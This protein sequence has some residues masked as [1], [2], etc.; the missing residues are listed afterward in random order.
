MEHAANRTTEK[1]DQGEP[2]DTN[3]AILKFERNA[4]RITFREAN[5]RK[6]YMDMRRWELHLRH[7]RQKLP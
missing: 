6:F 7:A 4:G 5:E 2:I 3:D 1:K